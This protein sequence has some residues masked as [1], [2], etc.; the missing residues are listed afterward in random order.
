[1]LFLKAPS[2]GLQDGVDYMIASNDLTQDELIEIAR[3]VQGEV[4]KISIQLQAL[5]QSLC[6]CFYLTINYNT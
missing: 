6:F 2:L 5:N 1:M 3:T 4:G